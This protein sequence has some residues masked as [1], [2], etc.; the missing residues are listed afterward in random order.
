MAKSSL[1]FES[2]W[3]WET[4]C[5][6]AACSRARHS[7]ICTVCHVRWARWQAVLGTHQIAVLPTLLT[8]TSPILS[9]AAMCPAKAILSLFLHNKGGPCDVVVANEM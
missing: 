7:G 1:L 3:A 5:L 6:Q 4:H 8:H 2:L 9:R